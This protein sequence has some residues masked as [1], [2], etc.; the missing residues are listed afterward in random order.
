MHSY[1]TQEL[2][3]LINSSFP[4]LEDR[5]GITGHSM[6]GHGALILAMKNPGLYHSVSAF[7]PICNPIECP[8]G[9]KAF[10][11]DSQCDALIG[12]C[13]IVGIV[14]LIKLYLVIILITYN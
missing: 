1:V 5:V 3:S 11:G 14:L 13:C 4:V 9:K 12:V 6:G 8:W 7:A 2:P 10:S